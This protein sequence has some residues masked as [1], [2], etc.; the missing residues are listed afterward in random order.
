MN[1][2]IVAVVGALALTTCGSTQSVMAAQ[3]PTK[4]EV[5][6]SIISFCQQ[7]YQE[8]RTTGSVKSFS[9][10]SKS[11]SP[12]DR[13]TLELACVAY[14]EGFDDGKATAHIASYHVANAGVVL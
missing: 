1:K 9:D 3:Q 12:S 2:L 6:K 8:Y 14:A 11:L 7:S 10:V 4:M 5:F 13:G